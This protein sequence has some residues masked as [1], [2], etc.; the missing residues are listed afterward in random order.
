ML[1]PFGPVL[2]PGIFLTI[3]WISLFIMLPIGIKSQEESG[4]IVKGTDP[5]AP[6]VTG[7]ARKLIY[8]TVLAV[9]IFTGVLFAAKRWG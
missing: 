3:W 6:V 2:G 4:T 8:N 5:G 7:M 1:E 9:V